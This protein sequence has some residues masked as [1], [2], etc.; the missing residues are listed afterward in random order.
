MNITKIPTDNHNDSSDEDNDLDEGTI[1]GENDV[2]YAEFSLSLRTSPKEQINGVSV[3][4]TS[5]SLTTATIT[6][7]TENSSRSQLFD[8]N[9]NESLETIRNNDDFMILS[10]S[11]LPNDNVPLSSN[12]SGKNY[13]SN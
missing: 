2:E 9:K 12:A 1:S 5:T 4:D 11:A 6:T 13:F 8:G 3:A 7:G 10:L